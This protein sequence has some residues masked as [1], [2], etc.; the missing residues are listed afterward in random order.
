M[1][2]AG[3]GSDWYVV[4]IV[5]TLDTEHFSGGRVERYQCMAYG[6]WCILPILC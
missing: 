3:S 4:G 6:V 2:S 1:S 5:A